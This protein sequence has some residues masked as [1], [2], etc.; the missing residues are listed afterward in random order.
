M[1][2]WSIS[3]STPITSGLSSSLT[4]SF[5]SSAQPQARTRPATEQ[6]ESSTSASH[7]HHASPV[8]FHDYPIYHYA[9]DGV[10]ETQK[11]PKDLPKVLLRIIDG[12]S[13]YVG[14]GQSKTANI[15]HATELSRRLKKSS[16]AA[17]N[18]IIAL[19]VHPGDIG[20]GLFREMH[21]DM[22]AE[23]EK[24]GV[25]DMAENMKTLDQGA[26]TTI[27]AAF[28]P[29]LGELDLGGEDGVIG[30]MV[31]CQ[32]ADEAVA[33]HAKDRYNAEMLYN[34]SERMLAT[35]TGL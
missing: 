15:L 24:N 4:F 2:R 35:R 20:T 27:V 31:D 34:E 11:P 12:Y 22:R 18:N 25:T 19:S 21:T 30:Y 28:D 17:D 16:S 3:S 14:Y 10:A 29:K 6:R 7:G 26:A 32:L 23:L 5:P 8:R 13:G 33:E 1:G 9:C